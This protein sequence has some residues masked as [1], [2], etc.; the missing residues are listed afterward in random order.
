[1]LAK[2]ACAVI[3]LAAVG[4]PAKAATVLFD[5]SGSRSASFS[6]DAMAT[7]TFSNALQSQFSDVSGTFN[8]VM[9]RAT[10]NFQRTGFEV[11]SPDLGFSQFISDAPLFTG[12]TSSPTFLP[13]TFQLRSIV[14]GQSILM[15]VSVGS[16]VPEPAAWAFML[17]G[18]GAVGYSMR[19]KPKVSY[20][21]TQAA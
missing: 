9:G 5:L 21:R 18:F 2:F 14:S 11:V 19:R 12:P 6:L 17:V 4:A 13:G 3:A 10:I 8:G 16:A 7:P 20:S 1:M 15:V